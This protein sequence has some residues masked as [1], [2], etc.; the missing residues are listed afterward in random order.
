MTRTQTVLSVLC[1][2]A[3]LVLVAAAEVYGRPRL[4]VVLMLVGIGAGFAVGVWSRGR[5]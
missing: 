4:W 3:W 2:F 5:K 1:L